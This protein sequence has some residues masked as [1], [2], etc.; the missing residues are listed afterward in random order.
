MSGSHDV[1]RLRENSIANKYTVGVPFVGVEAISGTAH[2]LRC[3]ASGHLLV[4]LASGAGQQVTAIVSGTVSAY[5]TGLVSAVVSGT[6]SA[7]VSG[8]VSAYVTGLVTANTELAA[9]SAAGDALANPTV[10]GILGFLHGWN[11]KDGTDKWQRITCEYASA[12]GTGD[13]NEIGMHVSSTPKVNTDWQAITGVYSASAV[14]TATGASVSV[15]RF[16]ECLLEVAFG[17]VTGTPTDID[18][19]VQMSDD[20]TNWYDYVKGPFGALIHDDL[21]IGTGLQ[22]CWDFRAPAEHLRLKVTVAGVQM[23]T[24]KKFKIDRA[25]ITEKS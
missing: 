2:L 21:T 5:V 23:A 15:R 13:A 11:T 12:T 14:L 25:R 22:R 10:P 18:V 24:P 19:Q 6:V 16:R 8:S 7:Y 3:N 9:A 1:D 20:N 4:G 17:A